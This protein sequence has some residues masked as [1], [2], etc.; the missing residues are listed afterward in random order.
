MN[1]PYPEGICPACVTSQDAKGSP[2][3]DQP[4]ILPSGP[5]CAPPQTFAPEPELEPDIGHEPTPEFK[6]EP[7][8]EPEQASEPKPEPEP[9]PELKL[10]P[11]PEAD[12]EVGKYASAARR[13]EY[14][15]QR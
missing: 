4:R 12:G 3:I 8:A 11:G 14:L 6:P 13:V 1:L 7:E 2:L 15:S 5:P 9:E 10:G